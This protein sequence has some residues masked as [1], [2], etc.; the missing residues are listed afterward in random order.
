MGILKN[1][2]IVAGWATVWYAGL[3]AMKQW[4]I[5]TAWV[6]QWLIDSVAWNV[7]DVLGSAWAKIGNLAPVSQVFIDELSW[8]LTH[9]NLIDG[10]V[11]LGLGAVWGFIGSTWSKIAGNMIWVK[12]EKDDKTAGIG[13]GV[14]TG[15]SVLWAWTTGLTIAAGTTGWV[16]WRKLGEKILGE[17]YAHIT[18]SIWALGVTG[19]AWWASPSVIFGS[20]AVAAWSWLIWK[21]GISPLGKWAKSIRQ[22][23]HEKRQGRK[24]K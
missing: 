4:W 7:V 17:K 12:S 14:G 8:V 11:A 18:A 2:G 24:K 3:E 13:I 15:L 20:T 19:L 5:E 10:G 22:R 23:N 21:Y 1:T 6:A 16:L 9:T